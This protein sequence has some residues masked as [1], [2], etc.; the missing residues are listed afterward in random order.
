MLSEAHR[1]AR[2]GKITSSIIGA[3]MEMDDWSSPYDALLKIKGDEIFEGNK[4]TERGTLLEPALLAFA[5]DQSCLTLR[6][7]AFVEGEAADGVVW[8]GDSADG[9]LWDEHQ[10]KLVGVIE[11]KTVNGH[12]RR[13][14]GEP[15]TDDVP[16]RVLAQA[17]WHLIH[18]PDAQTCYIP[19]LFG[20]DAFS[21]EMY[22]VHRDTE[23]ESYLKAQ[24]LA[25]HKRHVQG[26]ESVPL[27][28][29]DADKRA[30]LRKAPRDWDDFMPCDDAL[31]GLIAEHLAAD[32][33][34]KDA[35]KA[36]ALTANKLREAI[37]ESAGIEAAAQ[38]YSVTY[39]KNKDG[40]KTDWAAV[41][42]ELSASEE[43]I[44]RH[45]KVDVGA[46]VLRVARKRATKK[47]DVS[48]D[49]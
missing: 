44:Y 29:S 47:Q 46:R 33:A 32:K 42:R 4:A 14:W 26:D 39:R 15:G 2:L 9:L 27:S 5:A 8:S 13:G 22:Q 6:P 43:L 10:D 49:Q 18:W 48:D 28:S 36:L 17:Y 11:A 19:V 7:A 34:A 23:F 31:E 25:W 24:A 3:V 38:G 41:A 40:A 30:L 37:G 35:A 1:A 21:F 45:T 16:Q 12:G 20:G